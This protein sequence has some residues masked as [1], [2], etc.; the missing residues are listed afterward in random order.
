MTTIRAN[1][2][3][4]MLVDP[5]VSTHRVTEND[6]NAIDEVARVWA[7]IADETN[8]AIDLVHH[9]RKTYGAEVT[10]EDG[11]GASAL[12]FASR[13]ARALN[14]MTK[15]E[16]AKAGA[17]NNR[18]FF[19]EENGKANLSPPIEKATWFKLECVSRWEIQAP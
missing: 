3:D 16:A 14:I 8:T 13:S 12:V 10:V 9:T 17:E 4:V 1:R 18:L 11:R 7:G 15:E 2:I 6:N 19:R 5:F